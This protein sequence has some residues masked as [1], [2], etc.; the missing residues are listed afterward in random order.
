M[1][2]RKNVVGS[3]M[4]STTILRVPIIKVDDFTKE[5]DLKKV[6]DVIEE[7]F[8]GLDLS[9]ILDGIYIGNFDI[10][11]K[12][13]INAVF[14]E[15]VI[16]VSNEQDDS[17]DL[18]DDLVHEF[19][20]AIEHAAEAEVYGDASVEHEFSQKRKIL[21]NRLSVDFSEPLLKVALEWQ[22]PEYHQEIDGL[23]FQEIGY[24]T[25]AYLTYDIFVSPYAATSLSEFFATGFEEFYIGEKDTGR[26]NQCDC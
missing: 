6:K 8:L 10:L 16:Y 5:I 15:D 20:H 19:A 25:I 26:R 14:H 7:I 13:F 9:R 4:K 2:L 23:L 21:F 1:S 12:R 22:S 17:S 11:K 24:E 18:I 3:A